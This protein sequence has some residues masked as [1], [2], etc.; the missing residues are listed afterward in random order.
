[1]PPHEDAFTCADKARKAIDY[2][3]F[4]R[5]HGYD[6]PVFPNVLMYTRGGP[7]A[8]PAISRDTRNSTGSDMQKTSVLLVCLG[9]AASMGHAQTQVDL[10]SQARNVDFS[11]AQST[12]P[13][14]T[15]SILPGVCQIG[16][17]FF[18][19]DAPAGANL[20]GCIGPNIWTAL[21]S[22]ANALPSQTGNTGKA[23]FTVNGATYW[24][25]AV[26][27]IRPGTGGG[28]VVNCQA[29]ADGFS[30]DCAVQADSAYLATQGG[31][32]F[33]NGITAFTPG[34]PQ[35]ITSGTYTILA[36][37]TT[38]QINPASDIT[39]TGNPAVADGYSGQLL[40]IVNIN[41]ATRVTFQ[42]EASLPG[43][44]LRLRSASLTLEPRQV[45]TLLFDATVGDWVQVGG[46]A[47]TGGSAPAAPPA[48]VSSVFGRTGAIQKAKGDYSLADL[49]DVQA[50]KGNSGVVQMFGG[51]S[52]AAGTCA[53]FDASGNIVSSG[54][55]CGGG[56]GT[57]TPAK[58]S[59]VA[60]GTSGFT[61][62]TSTS[63]TN[64]ATAIIPAQTLAIGDRVIIR[65]MFLHQG[66]TAAN[67]RPTVSFG[68][69]NLVFEAGMSGTD[70][71]A[72]FEAELIVADSNAQFAY[73]RVHRQNG[74]LL[75]PVRSAPTAD[76]ASNI[77][78]QFDARLT[79]AAAES[80]TLEWYSVEVVKR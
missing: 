34:T 59:L 78:V 31:P 65:A 42:D 28:L 6:K 19:T 9:A 77:A 52:T 12:K 25:R 35:A 7:T 27:S 37:G 46:G 72:I 33:F 17:T 15:G 32:N 75:A 79:S 22:P 3:P 13:S 29:G 8:I 61:P 66:G 20:Y 1:M 55:P 48:P 10:R 58:S 67:P 44:N 50:A 47:G 51:G 4:S 41:T 23:L 38:V 11:T 2:W 56:G 60:S 53:Q 54:A 70:T 26:K 73:A 49:G 63:Q 18:K 76:I 14:K 64:I 40:H 69:T 39:L 45:L 21:G 80:V 24:D 57:T 74:S 30:G 5:F 43:S 71:F 16:E 36:N 68:G 62:A